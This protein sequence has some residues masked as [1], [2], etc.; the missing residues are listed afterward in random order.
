MGFRFWQSKGTRILP[1][2]DWTNHQPDQAHEEETQ[3]ATIHET[4][5]TWARAFTSL[6]KAI[7]EQITHQLKALQLSVVDRDKLCGLRNFAKIATTAC[8]SEDQPEQECFEELLDISDDV[9]VIVD[10]YLDPA[11]KKIKRAVREAR[12][13]GGADTDAAVAKAIET[14]AREVSE[15]RRRVP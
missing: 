8:D 12:E 4:N 10:R 9:D 1:G 11:A 13:K 3:A 6:G 5:A 14:A 7:E 15:A 2:T